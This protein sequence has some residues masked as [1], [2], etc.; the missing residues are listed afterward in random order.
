MSAAVWCRFVVA[1]AEGEEGMSGGVDELAEKQECGLCF[2]G[3]DVPN[4]ALE[5]LGPSGMP[6]CLHIFLL[7]LGMDPGFVRAREV[8]GF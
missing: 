5:G 4:K 3:Q 1:G 8:L 2:T 7:E 6:W